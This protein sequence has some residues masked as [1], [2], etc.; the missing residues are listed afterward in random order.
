VVDLARPR[1]PRVE[2]GAVAEHALDAEHHVLDLA[3]APRALAR[4]ARR[5]P[6]AHGRAV[7]GRGEVPERGPAPPE[8]LLEVL[9]EDARVDDAAAGLDVDLVERAHAL[10]VDGDDV[11]RRAGW[12]PHAAARAV[13]EERDAARRG[14]A[15]ELGELLVAL[16]PHDGAGPR[17]AREA[18]PRRRRSWRGQRSWAYALRSAASSETLGAPGHGRLDRRGRGARA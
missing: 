7:D 12:R 9:A 18:E 10:H 11:A 5:H 2:G 16:G 4:R 8:L 3:V 6:A 13:G 17:R 1:R 15:E 14:E